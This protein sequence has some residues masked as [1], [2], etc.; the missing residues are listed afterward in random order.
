MH[1]L[2]SSWPQLSFEKCRKAVKERG[3]RNK[4]AEKKET[5][6]KKTHGDDIIAVL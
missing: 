3:R 6:R 1:P 4:E 5:Q 2:L